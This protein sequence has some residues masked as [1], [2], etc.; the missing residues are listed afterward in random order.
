MSH[1]EITVFLVED[2][3]ADAKRVEHAFAEAHIGNRLIRARDELQARDMMRTRLN[4]E[5]AG[6]HVLL[7][8]PKVTGDCPSFD[9][10]LH[11]D[12]ILQRALVFVLTDSRG[13]EALPP[14]INV[15]GYIAKEDA[16]H[17]FLASMHSIGT[18]VRLVEAPA[19]QMLH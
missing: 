2:D 18:Y 9:R 14:N 1:K 17:G 12:E 16:G 11:T 15:A 19:G 4:E 7:V 10:R 3:D 8:D 13:D 6:A 5:P